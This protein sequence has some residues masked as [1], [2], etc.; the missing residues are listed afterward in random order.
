M[1]QKLQAKIDYQ[2]KT[3]ALLQTAFVHRSYVNE[4]KKV[5][6]HNER[7]EFLGD[8]VLE[9]IVTEFLYNRFPTKPEGELTALR[10]ALVKGTRLAEVAAALNLG[11]F[12]Q[13]S[14]GEQKSGGAQKPYLLANVF[15]ALLGAIYLD[16]NLAQARKFVTRFLLPQIKKILATQE[17]IDAKSH[18][19]EL[20][21]ARLA[22]TPSYELV[23]AEGPDHA[24]VFEMAVKIGEETFGVGKGPN[25]QSAEQAAAR[26]G[27]N[28]LKT[29]RKKSNV[30]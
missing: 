20:T 4:V 24:K 7:L 18:F 21:Q 8:A 25:K 1:L 12:L 26:A 30:S 2:F 27:L 14:Y 16:A 23:S 28:K 10:S 13:L 9:L 11:D 6:E 15:E 29:Y 17:Q 19:Q 5:K 3:P 22:L